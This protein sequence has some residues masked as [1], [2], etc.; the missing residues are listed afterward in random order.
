MRKRLSRII[1]S[2]LVVG[3]SLA[4]ASCTTPDNTQTTPSDTSN[5]A[6]SASP[7]PSTDATGLPVTPSPTISQPAASTTLDGIEATGGFGESPEV[8]VPSPWAIDSTKTKILVQGTG[9]TVGVAGLIQVNYYGVNAR[10][11]EMFDESYSGGTPAVFALNGVIPGFQ[12]GLS[13]Q[14]VG[15]RLIIAIPGADGYDSNGGQP[16]ANI[17]IGDTLV[18]VADIISCQLAV[19]DGQAVT[20]TDAS[21]PEVTGEL[22]AP[23][24]TI[25]SDQTPPSSLVV[26]PLITGQGPK[27]GDTDGILVDYAEYIWSSGSLVRQTYGYSPLLGSMTTALPTWVQVLTQQA[28]GSG[29]LPGWQQGLAEQTVGSRVLLVV[30]PDLAYPQGDAKNKIPVDSTMVYVIDIL[31]AA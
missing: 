27:V 13:G 11:G 8:T 15:T 10:T 16:S 25:N 20:V 23:I 19:S 3:V 26:Q 24:V 9:P 7:T 4:M 31:F 28:T 12:K 5:A 17:A 14:K 21:L 22:D 30:P 6:T 2:I 18:F 1:G 29:V